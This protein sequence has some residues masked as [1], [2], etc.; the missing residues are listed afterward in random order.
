VVAPGRHTA[1]SGCHDTMTLD[2]F[3]PPCYHVTQPTHGHHIARCA[4][5]MW[6]LCHHDHDAAAK[7]LQPWVWPPLHPRCPT[8]DTSPGPVAT[9]TMPCCLIASPVHLHC[10]HQHH[11]SGK[12][13]VT[14]MPC[15]KLT[16]PQVH[17]HQC[18]APLPCHLTSVPTSQHCATGANTTCSVSPVL[19]PC[20][21]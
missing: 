18:H 12:C 6:P 8:T 2:P 4:T 11:A 16:C 1:C 21:S 10:W 9:S 17:S 19:P 3:W 13:H 5:L 20:P 14:T 7:S 15:P